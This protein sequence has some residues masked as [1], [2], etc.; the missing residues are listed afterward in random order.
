MT[1]TSVDRISEELRSHW[2]QVAANDTTRMQTDMRVAAIGVSR[3]GPHRRGPRAGRDAS[4]A[5]A[6]DWLRRHCQLLAS[7]RER[8]EP[9]TPI[10]YGPTDRSHRRRVARS[11]LGA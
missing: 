10:P 9:V 8:S 11:G 1:T 6:G 3:R 2:V 5:M 7:T 4:E